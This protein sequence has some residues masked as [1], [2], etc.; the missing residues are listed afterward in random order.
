MLHD[1]Y[2]MNMTNEGKNDIEHLYDKKKS[3]TQL[4]LL[5]IYPIQNK[6][7]TTDHK[8]HPHLLSS[9]DRN[10]LAPKFQFE[11]PCEFKKCCYKE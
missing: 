2:A 9:I 1:K 8:Q 4:P 6:T 5:G 3:R 10:L 11:I 7:T